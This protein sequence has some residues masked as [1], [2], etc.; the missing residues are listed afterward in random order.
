MKYLKLK[1]LLMFFALAMAIPPAWAETVTDVINREATIDELGDIAS[2][3]WHPITLEG[4]SGAEYYIYTMGLKGL[5]APAINWSANG[6]MYATKSGGKLVSVTV[7]GDGS[8]N[9][10]V[11]IFATNTAYSSKPTGTPLA[12][13]KLSD[14]G[15][16]YNFTDNYAYIAIN[17]KSKSTRPYSITIVWEVEGS[18]T[19]K[20]ATP[21][22]S[23]AAGTY[24][25][26]QN[27]EIGCATD[28]ATIYYTTDGT[29]PTTT[30]TEYTSAIS[31]NETMTLKAIAVKSGMDNS[32]VA[33]ATYTINLPPVPSGI[34]YKKVN[35]S[36]LKNGGTYVIIYEGDPAAA[37]G[38]VMQVSGSG[39]KGTAV[40]GIILDKTTNPYQVDLASKNALML[41][42]RATNTEG[43]YAFEI[44]Q[45]SYLNCNSAS[46]S[47]VTSSTGINAQWDILGDGRVISANTS[48]NRAIIYCADV[49]LFGPYASSNANGNS[50]YFYAYLYEKVDGSGVERVATPTFSPDGGAYDEP[51]NVTISCETPN[52]T[53]YYT[54][55]G[56]TPDETSTQYTGAIEVN[57]TTTIK[58]IAVASGM[59]NSYVATATYTLPKFV[60]N[61]TGANDLETNVSFKYTGYAEV[62]YVNGT[63][64]WIRDDAGTGGYLYRA[65]SRASFDNGDVLKA[66]W[67][68]TKDEFHGLD[69]FKDVSGLEK[70]GAVTVEPEVLTQITDADVNKYV[71]LVNVSESE[72]VDGSGNA[73]QLYNKFGTNYTFESGK[74]YDVVGIVGY[75][76][77]LQLHIISITEHGEPTIEVTPT[78]MTLKEDA[79]TF[80]VTG[81]NLVDNVGM[82]NNNHVFN[83]TYSGDADWGFVK[84][85][86]G[87]VN[88]TVTVTYTGRELKAT[89]TFVAGTKK[90]W[91]PEVE[92]SIPVTVTYQPDIYIVGNINNAG[93]NFGDGNRPMSY[94]E[95]TGLYTAQLTTTDHS[96]FMFAR[97]PGQ[98][99][100]WQ[101]DKNRLFFGAQTDGGNWVLGNDPT[102][103]IDVEGTTGNQYHPIELPSAGEYTI[104]INP[105]DKKFTITKVVHQVET[106]VISPEGGNYNTIQTVTITA[107]DGATIHYTTDGT[108]PTESSTLYEGPI[109]VDHSMTIKAIAVMDGMDNSEVATAT[110]T[111]PTSVNTL[112]AANALEKNTEFLFTGDAVVTY[113]NGDYTFLRDVNAT[114]GGGLIY[115]SGINLAQGVVLK[116]GWDAKRDDYRGEK[117]YINAINVENSGNTADYTP[118]DRTGVAFADAHMNEYVTFNNVTI[119]GKT[120]DEGSGK[121]TYTG[122]YTDGNRA[123]VDYILHN[124][125]DLN[126]I[127]E[128]R[129]YNVTGVVTKRDDNMQ[130]YPTAV[131]LVK[132]D[133]GLAFNPTSVPASFGAEFTEPELT[134]P[135]DLTGITYESNNTAVAT[136]DENGNVDIVGVGSATITASVTESDYYLAGQ[137]SY[138][139]T[140]SKANAKVEYSAETATATFGAE[141]TL[142]TVSTTPTDLPLTY[143]SSNTAVATVNENGEVSIVGAGETT[144][145][146]KFAG[147][148]NYNAAEDS[149]VLTVAKADAKV[150]YSAETATA[151]FGVEATLPTLTVTPNDLEVTY[152]STNTAVATVDADGKVT[153]KGVGTTTISA[154]F[155]GD[156]NYNEA[157]DSYTL[158]VKPA[159]AT[160]TYSA[161]TATATYGVE[162]TLPTLNNPNG[163]T[164]TYESSK[165]EVATVDADGKVTIK[166]AGQTTITAYGAATGNYG[167]ATASYE[168]TVNKGDAGLS[169]S[170]STAS[171]VVGS[172]FTAPTLTGVPEGV[173]V[174]YTSSNPEVATVDENGNVTIVGEGTTTITAKITGDANYE[175]AEVSY[176]LTVAPQPVV[177]APTFSLVA[178]TYGEAQQLT[179]SAENGATILYSTDGSE[180]TTEY[181]G[182]AIDLGQGTTT[183]KAVATKDGFA[184]SPVVTATYIIDIPEVLPTIEPFKGY[185]Q[186]KNNGN[187]MYANIAGRKTLNFADAENAKKMAGTVIWLETNDKGQVQSLRSQ[188][189]DLQGYANRAMRYVPQMVDI[190]VNKINEMEGIEDATGAGSVLGETGLDSIMAKFNECFDYHL[191]VEQA[192][193]GWRLYGKTPN[194][195]HVV[196]FYRDHKDQVEAKLPKLEQFIND[197]LDKLINKIGGSTVF[198]DFSLLNIWERMGGTLTKPEDDAS[199][200]AFYR[201]VLNNKNYVWDFAYQTAQIY[202]GNVKNHPRYDE[203]KAQLGEYADYIDEFVTQVRPDFKYYVIQRGDEP[204]YISEGNGEIISNDP[205]TLWTL[206]PR[207]DFTVNIAGEQFGCPYAGGVG[208][209]ATTNYTDFAYTVPES[210]T[211][212]KV[213]SVENGVANLQ[214]LSGVIPAQ[215]PVLLMAKEAGDYVLTLSTEAGTKVTGNL[216][217]GVDS[218]ITRFQ[219]K[220][221]MVETLFNLAQ[222]VLGEQLY[223]QYVAQYEYLQLL[224]SG[225]VNNKYF[226]GLTRDDV[227][228]CLNAN[229]DDCVVRDLSGSKFIDNRQV[230]T[231]KAFLVSETDQTI[232]ISTLRGDVNHDGDVNIVD[233]TALIDRLLGD[234][235]HS[236]PYCSDVNSDNDVNIKDVTDL[237]DILLRSGADTHVDTPTP[238]PEGGNGN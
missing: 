137:A 11:D 153:I 207:T 111:L 131:T 94:D 23:P 56:S 52:S 24:S 151:T 166:G 119:T 95:A 99:Y 180:P 181:T 26:A 154:A 85:A 146:A 76:D 171:A 63:D 178:G 68:A 101:G 116:K 213:A 48:T 203:L 194:M 156:N 155:A 120:L 163:L 143:E 202:W 123:N 183:V 41:T 103:N 47:I 236:C 102:G 21:T 165:P 188:A 139:I 170:A 189:A 191:Y 13:V 234:G 196:D 65:L 220:T 130:V 54:T 147:N 81:E 214:A 209:Y 187:N 144:I 210:V 142:P 231:N 15:T 6:Y 34:I 157:S 148:D 74:K 215:T 31:V 184:K 86:Q 9:K 179:I 45:G 225:T 128:G 122:T 174:T 88:G 97:K 80:T 62:T 38:E 205:R 14:T 169:F 43:R 160:F 186:I 192:Q 53:I 136:V 18:T 141:A 91:N 42:A 104:T 152:S 44:E 90:S 115:Q 168:L 83:T 145:K 177:A 211:A 19:E 164:V 230:K 3:S 150:E 73:V 193:G 135:A 78:A 96:Y 77:K 118:F 235:T 233:V 84:D 36:S 25:S 159:G 114:A 219:L 229:G 204:D 228:K 1:F 61:L 67:T 127:E 79:Q 29:T 32:V 82:P 57:E 33:S 105:T 232:T 17:S 51:K 182:A 227:M 212:Y 50:N 70:N 162:A 106:P 223:N 100:G 129:T 107:A 87:K 46:F 125:F 121:Y 93:W 238:D 237:I 5:T 221:P 138:T 64:A 69:E 55:D 40:T 176:E 10:S 206:E 49:N 28:G 98:N 30:S 140:V 8:E 208:G 108:E 2:S 60:T 75:Y 200:M 39:T 197:A 195:Q 109:T 126:N 201:E 132:Q 35:S 58:A 124:Q 71:K 216:L 37:M 16:T 12:T 222:G 112:A 172:D 59:D 158:T 27:V 22:F 167:A 20:V 89:D 110:Y 92:I 7:A 185:Y 117:E 199:I 66:G 161:P 4:N 190:V 72:I 218:L 217:V 133:P 173:T 198:T 113:H 224:Y 226:W 175:D 134:K 149:Y